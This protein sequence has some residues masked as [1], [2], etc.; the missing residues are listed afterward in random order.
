MDITIPCTA[1]NASAENVSKRKLAKST[2][3][4]YIAHEGGS[5]S[6][7]G[8]RTSDPNPSSGSRFWRTSSNFCNIQQLNLIYE[9]IY[10]NIFKIVIRI[11]SYIFDTYELVLRWVYRTYTFQNFNVENESDEDNVNKNRYHEN[12]FVWDM[13][14]SRMWTIFFNFQ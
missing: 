9:L 7:V 11:N 10:L 14:M 13:K 4:C 5:L 1:V 8:D 3:K 2:W 12:V 6:R